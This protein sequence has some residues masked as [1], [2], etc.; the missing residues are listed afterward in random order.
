MYFGLLGKDNC[1]LD[2][3]LFIWKK[4]FL[5]FCIGVFFGD[6]ILLDKFFF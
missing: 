4:I 5:E 1:L 6:I 3:F 2:F